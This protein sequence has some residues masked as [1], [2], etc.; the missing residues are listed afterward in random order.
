MIKSSEIKKAALNKLDW[1]KSLL[2]STI[3]VLTNL[4][5]SYALEFGINTGY[6]IDL[7]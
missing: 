6:Y 4:A 5:L 7:E 1:K 3:F 2:V